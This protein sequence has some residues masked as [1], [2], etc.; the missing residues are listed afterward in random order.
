M[1]IDQYIDATG[2]EDFIAQFPMMY[3]DA[4]L[5][6]LEFRLLLHYAHK[7]K[8]YESV[9]TTAKK[10]HMSTGSVSQKRTSLIEK[11][12]ITSEGVSEFGTLFISVVDKWKENNLLYPS[13]GET[14]ILIN[15]KDLI[16]YSVSGDETHHKPLSAYVEAFGKFRN[17]D[18]ADAVFTIWMEYGEETFFAVLEWLKD[19]NFR[20]YGS[21]IKAFATAAAKWGEMNAEENPAVIGELVT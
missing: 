7:K 19:K 4:D 8:T 10:C 16:K 6:P 3:M 11:G 12:W 9:A 18:Q 1:S 5:D 20:H 21:R 17:E 2:P 15:L 14:S 13:P